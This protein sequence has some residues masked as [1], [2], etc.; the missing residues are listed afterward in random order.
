[1]P[2]PSNVTRKLPTSP[3]LPPGDVPYDQR[4]CIYMLAATMHQALTNYAPEPYPASAP[5]LPV[6]MFNPAVSPALE[7]I[8]NRA[9]QEDRERRY[10]SF[11]EMQRDIKRLL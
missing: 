2:P 7:A 11:E 4:T 8:L 10:Q 3:Y 5:P 6:H 9:L 1:M